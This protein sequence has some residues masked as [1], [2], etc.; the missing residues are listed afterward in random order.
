MLG[1]FSLLYFCFLVFHA[2]TH[3]LHVTAMV[4]SISQLRCFE[5]E[6]ET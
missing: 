6:S 5:L 1:L 3:Y 4:L 2:L